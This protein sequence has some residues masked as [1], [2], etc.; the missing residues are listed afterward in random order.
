M[1][2]TEIEIMS[3]GQALKKTFDLV[4]SKKNEIEEFFKEAKKV[5][6]TGCG[7]GYSICKSAAISMNLNTDIVSFAV[8]AGD[9]MINYKHYHRML[10]DSI[11]IAPSRSGSTS[12]VVNLIEITKGIYNTKT[13]CICAKE[14]SSL[15]KMSELSI[16]IPW[17]FDESVCQ[18]RTVTNL[19]TVNLMLCAIIGKNTEL[20][21][22]IGDAI[23]NIEKF[24]NSFKDTC[25]KIGESDVWNKVVVLADS[26]PEGIAEEG[27]LAFK[28]IC[29]LPSNY[30]HVL[31]SR[32][33][34]MVLY[35]KETLVI[36]LL[37]PND[38]KYQS[39]FIKD[40]K[41]RNCT[42]VTLSQNQ[43]CMG[44]SDYNIVIPEYKNYPVCGIPFIT[45]PQM[46]SLY[47]ALHIG[48]NPDLPQGLDPW[49]KL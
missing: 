31:D 30:Y 5:I 4:I 25:K 10:T 32:H 41:K 28:E 16:E 2:K 22:E 9:A 18:T 12:E 27:S 13:V 24:I 35:D 7:S 26:E 8:A 6:F 46:I 17:A 38:K 14:N 42:V 20:L 11:I 39:D 3:Q 34:P 48:I 36:A 43:A 15:S 44:D 49:I 45:V 47:K 23:N 29:Q 21:A 1:Y 40:V 19:Y 33:G 37:S